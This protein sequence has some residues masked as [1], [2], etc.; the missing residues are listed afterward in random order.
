MP[1]RILN[2]IFNPLLR[3]SW[4]SVL[5]LWKPIAIWTGLVYIFFTA[6]L[7]PVFISLL[8]RGVFRGE[9]SMVGNEELASFLLSPVGFSYLFLALLI[10]IT[11]VVIRYAGIFQIITDD[12]MGRDLSTREIILHIAPRIHLIVKLCALS[13]VAAILLLLPL[14]AGL[15][16]VYSIY[17][18][19]FDINYYLFTSPP[20]WY[21]ALWWGGAWAVLW[22][23]FALF[24]ITAL[25]PVLPA[26]LDGRRS[27][28]E[29]VR[30]LFFTPMYKKL[31]LLKAVITAILIWVLFRFLFE[32]I[33]LSIFHFLAGW[34]YT[35]FDSLRLL[36]FVAGNY[37]FIAFTAGVII[38]F[39]GFS[40]LAVI[41]TKFYYSYA[42]PE[43][44][45]EI[46]GLKKITHKMVRIVGWWTKPLRLAL[47]L[48]AILIGGLVS[49]FVI[50][51]LADDD[52]P[53]ILNIA[54]RAN[55]LGAPEN[56]IAA[57]KNSIE[58]GADMAEIDLQMTADGRI[59]ILHDADLMRVAGDPRRIVDVTYDEIRDL[60]LLTDLDIPDEELVIPTFEDFLEIADG[61]IILLTELK[62][63]GFY[64]E[65]AVEAIRLIRE[66]RMEDQ[67]P[68][69][70]LSTRSVNQ[71]REIAPDI[72]VGYVSALAAG[73]LAAMPVHFFA[74]SHQ[75]L[76]S[77]FIRETTRNGQPV[78]AWTVNRSE[79]M[80]NAMQRGA[81]GLITDEPVLA[82]EMI[83]QFSQLTRAERL[84]LQFGLFAVEGGE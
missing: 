61:Q 79:D 19:E 63:Y 23:M 82:G 1:K 40:L 41:L 84:L 39:F 75:N 38:S 45:F 6:L 18:T 46:P 62:Y 11:G 4:K 67:S 12:L 83:E 31:Q 47:L 70:S 68:L 80:I 5:K 25:L 74:I 55:A 77:G 24:C 81:I 8:N 66:Y 73:D 59:V 28:T 22:L 36:A 56:S 35:T 14:A 21:S 52:P 15:G 2:I 60:R 3:S 69:M 32:A 7:A 17:L 44:E 51:G 13:I 9:R 10:L 34:V 72:D 58:I 57:L 43:V 65:L 49:S 27:L 26:Y 42:L 20:E 33:N 29:A 53:E 71:V 37:L 16:T 78:Y 50:A 48:S 54:H 64:P 30:D 76:N